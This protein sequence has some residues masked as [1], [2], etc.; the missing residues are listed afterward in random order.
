MRLRLNELKTAQRI[1]ALIKADLLFMAVCDLLIIRLSS[2]CTSHTSRYYHY[3]FILFKKIC[4]SH[5][6]VSLLLTQSLDIQHGIAF[7]LQTR[8]SSFKLRKLGTSTMWP[9]V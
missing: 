3:D 4:C 5:R 8:Q 9:C 7:W 6:L 1:K 2:D